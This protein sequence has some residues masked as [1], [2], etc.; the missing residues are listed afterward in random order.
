[1]YMKKDNSIPGASWAKCRPPGQAGGKKKTAS[2]KWM[3]LTKTSLAHP[4]PTPKHILPPYLEVKVLIIW[5]PALARHTHSPGAG[6]ART[7]AQPGGCLLSRGALPGIQQ[8]LCSNARMRM[9]AQAP[10]AAGR[11]RAMGLHGFPLCPKA[12]EPGLP[13]PQGAMG[14][15][16]LHRQTQGLAK[17]GWAT[18][19]WAQ[20]APTALSRA[21]TSEEVLAAGAGIYILIKKGKRNI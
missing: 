7:V 5:K 17:G 14:D 12:K 16:V 11:P 2:K 13:T 4:S 3:N 18:P 21:A 1:M 20:V 8:P 10:R 9:E 15:A 6:E 19:C